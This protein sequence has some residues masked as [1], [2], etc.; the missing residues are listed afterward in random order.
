MAD[1]AVRRIDDMEGA[2]WNTAAL[3]THKRERAGVLLAGLKTAFAPGGFLQYGQGKWY[4]GESLPR[5]VY[6][7]YWR[8]DGQ[9]LWRLPAPTS[10]A[11]PA[12][13]PSSS[14]R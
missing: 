11:H 10:A 2:E 7:L 5:W 6:S 14:S 9:P 12:Q 1:Y 3:G 4:P 13:S 8:R